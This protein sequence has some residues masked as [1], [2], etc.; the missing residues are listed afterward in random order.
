MPS[1]EA[2]PAGSRWPLIE[3]ALI[4]LVGLACL[5]FQLRLPSREPTEA[6]YQQVQQAL[7]ADS[8]PGD[9]L[10]LYP[11][12]TERARLFA[13][14]QVTVVG[15]QG[16]DEDPLET[17]PRVWALWQPSLPRADE[18]AFLQTFGKNRT[19]VGPV[20][21]FG[22]LKLQL[23][24]NGRA[25]PV[26]FSATQALA[27]AHVYLEQP[28]GGRQDC[29]W[30]GR[31]HRCPNGE[32]AVEW[33]EV[34]FQPR[35]CLRF[36]PPGGA[37]RLVAEFPNVAASNQLALEAGFIWDRG[38][39]HEPRFTPTDFGVEVNEQPAVSL[40]I[41][42]GLEGL[43]R[44]TGGS[45]NEGST[46]KLWVRSQNPELREACVDVFGFGGVAQ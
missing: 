43:Q 41:S 23:F 25:K 28:G 1:L 24:Q 46:L 44:A 17:H 12:W 39:F 10:L 3:G 18:S 8:Q 35:H 5:W 14:P 13:P 22:H 16:S 6:E 7:T 21:E 26:V 42:A 9:A 30:N 19:A 37:S 34:H 32:V 38:W 20:R 15:Y 11:W 31:S 27:S 4:V 33:H 2:S 29:T 40:T 45:V 36:Y